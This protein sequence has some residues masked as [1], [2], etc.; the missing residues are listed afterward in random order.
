[1][2]DFSG[3]RTPLNTFLGL[4]PFLRLSLEGQDLLPLSQK[5]FE[6]LEEHSANADLLMNLS[7]IMQILGGEELG[8]DIQKQAL[9]LK[10]T[11][12]I[13]PAI[14]PAKYR[15]LLFMVPGVVSENTP[16]DCLLE[17]EAVELI[18]YFLDDK[19]PWFLED[20]PEH[21]IA[22][23]GVCASEQNG[24][25][26]EALTKKLAGWD[27]PVLNLP[28]FIGNT[29]RTRASEL[30]QDVPGIEIPMTFLVEKPV[31]TGLV[32]NKDRLAD[33]FEGVRFPIIIRPRDSHAG[34]DLEK[35]NDLD[36]LADYLQAV[37]CDEFFIS[38]FIDYSDEKGNFSKYRVVLIEGDAYICHKAISTHW[39]IH[40]VNA[41]MLEEQDKRDDE[42]KSMLHFDEFIG[43][44][45]DALSA[46]YEK[47]GLDYLGIDCAETMDGQL[48]IFEIDHVMVVHG[49]DPV[50]MFAYKLEPI[51]KI[52]DAFNQMVDDKITA[53]S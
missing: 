6:K 22:M 51:Q 34:R 40:Y 8:L 49:M 3:E 21:D 17:G 24:P 45:K 46:I 16:L 53:G 14:Q 20:I 10:R 39:M 12:R 36:A 7:M 33:S 23:V 2:N 47:T 41:G 43:R 35:M 48:L 15:L 1:M 52:K 50:D 28:E 32:A 26:L 37:D 30:L 27:K 13:P 42:A 4:A 9:L 38:N 25:A 31:L 44:H 29:Y 11:Y 5:I 18:F 19:E